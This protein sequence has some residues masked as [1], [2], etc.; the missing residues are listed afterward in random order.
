MGIHSYESDERQRQRY[1]VG[2]YLV[3]KKL[4]AVGA[5]GMIHVTQ[6]TWEP[7]SNLVSSPTP[8]NMYGNDT[9]FALLRIR[10]CLRPVVVD[11]YFTST[12][13]TEVATRSTDHKPHFGRDM[14]KRVAL[15]DALGEIIG[16]ASLEHSPLSTPDTRMKRM[17]PREAHY[18]PFS[19]R[20]H[21]KSTQAS[22]LAVG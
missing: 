18:T 14:W 4:C 7:Q 9:R 10:G 2:R 1:Q 6:E 20:A 17:I 19:C 3:S 22:V 16:W 8:E 21:P 12:E 11:G 13:D 15:T 5:V